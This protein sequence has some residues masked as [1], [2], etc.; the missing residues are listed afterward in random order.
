MANS[1]VLLTAKMDRVEGRKL[2]M[3]AK[4]QD[5]SGNI[6]ADST[7]LFVA[8]KSDAVYRT[9]LIKLYQDYIAPLLK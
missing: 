7:A 3:S 5:E 2:Y 4:M 6:L 9:Y 8:P 1:W